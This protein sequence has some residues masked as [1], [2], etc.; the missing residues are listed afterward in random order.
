[1]L[2]AT[3]VCRDNDS[4]LE[5]Y[6][7]CSSGFELRK[8]GRLTNTF[9][10]DLPEPPQMVLNVH[11]D[12]AGGLPVVA[13]IQIHLQSIFQLA[14]P[15]RRLGEVQSA[16]SIEAL[17]ADNRELLERLD[18]ELSRVAERDARQ[19]DGRA[20][21]GDSAARRGSRGPLAPPLNAKV[22]PAQDLQ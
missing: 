18:A 8:R 22:M 13:E 7:R 10:T 11:I 19:G 17:L 3:L 1:M 15:H 4:V 21:E 5:A 2:Q 6:S 12:S 9:N 14:K 16:A 20:G